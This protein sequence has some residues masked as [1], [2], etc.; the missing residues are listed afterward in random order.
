MTPKRI[1]RKK[2]GSPTAPTKQLKL[3]NPEVKNSVTKKRGFVKADPDAQTQLI[4]L[5]S[6]KLRSDITK[7]YN[8]MKAQGIDGNSGTAGFL[9]NRFE[10]SEFIKKAKK[11]NLTNAQALARFK[12][13]F[14][15]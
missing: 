1:R 11:D 12:K 9:L 15:L 2:K 8:D 14:K 5:N 3:V 10:M 6:K 4:Q 13:Q 7:V